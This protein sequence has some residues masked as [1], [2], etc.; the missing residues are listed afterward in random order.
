MRE[1]RARIE[2]INPHAVEEGNILLSE[3]MKGSFVAGLT[4]ERIKYVVKAKGEDNSL[5][6]LVET[7]LQEESELKSQNF[8][9]NQRKL[10]W[11]NA[12]YSGSIRRDYRPQV[13]REEVNVVTSLKCFKCHGVGHLARDCR[14]KPTCSSCHRFGHEARNC[15]ARS[16]QGNRN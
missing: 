6:Q 14:S 8:K 11:P 10:T 9:R 12:N 4:D 16:S 15:R 5:A 13:K 1:T 7:A 3:F 2:K